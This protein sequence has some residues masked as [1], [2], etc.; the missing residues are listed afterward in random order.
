MERQLSRGRKQ[1]KIKKKS[2]RGVDLK[3]FGTWIGGGRR[4]LS[5]YERW[6][7]M[8]VHCSQY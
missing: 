2:G 8:K 7:H 4:S 6:S 3:V 5:I 1:W